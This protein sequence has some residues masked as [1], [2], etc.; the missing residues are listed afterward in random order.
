[1]L[2]LKSKVFNDKEKVVKRV[3]ALSFDQIFCG[4]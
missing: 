4:I 3:D 1:M 2:N